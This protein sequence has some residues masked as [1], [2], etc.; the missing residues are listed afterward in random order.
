MRGTAFEKN[1]F[2]YLKLYYNTKNRNVTRHQ[3]RVLHI[4]NTVHL[5][6]TKIKQS[7]VTSI[8]V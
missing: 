1:K 4:V 6:N 8:V 7:T 3:V 2:K 5:S